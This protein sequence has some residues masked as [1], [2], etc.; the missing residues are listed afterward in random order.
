MSE[1]LPLWKVLLAE[2]K[3]L[4]ETPKP[5]PASLDEV[6]ELLHKKDRS[7]LCISGG[8]IRSASFA[9]GVIQGLAKLGASAADSVLNKIDYL[10]TV[11]GGGYVG[12]WLSGWA[13]RK[14][15]MEAVVDEL[16]KK[17]ADKL[18]PEPKPLHHLRE[19]SNYLTPKLGLLSADT[20]AF[21]GA[22][23]RNLLLMWLVLI[24]FFLAIL[25]LPRVFVSL[26]VNQI[27]I[28]PVYFKYAG[29]A[30]FYWALA[31][32][33]ITRPTA[34]PTP[35]KWIYGDY[36]FQLLCL[37]PL[38]L[39]AVTVV[40]AHSQYSFVRWPHGQWKL[41]ALAAGG[42]VLSSLI[43]T[44]R[45]IGAEG[46]G[47]WKKQLAELAAAAVSGVLLA[48]LL[49]LFMVQFESPLTMMK[50]ADT[51]DWLNGH[52]PLL[53][54]SLA[55]SYIVFG[56][57]LV[58]L[59]LLLQAT[60]FVGGTGRF[61]DDFDREWWG[62]AAAWVIIAGIGWIVVTAIVIYG[63]VG[64]YYAPRTIGLIGGVSGLFAVGA[65]KSGKTSA[66]NKE[67]TKESTGGTISNILL[68]LATPLFA[69]AL[70][71]ALSLGTTAL[72][73]VCLEQRHIIAPRPD[74]STEIEF[75]KR[76]SWT[77][78]QKQN[79][80]AVA[81]PRVAA[82]GVGEQ[83]LKTIE[84]PAIEADK[85]NGLDHLFVLE[86]TP[87]RT[88]AVLV[89]GAILIALLASSLIGVN[90]F[91]IH[92]LYRDRIVRGYLA[93]S[94]EQRKENP[95]T[96]FD[97][98]DNILINSLLRRPMHVVNMC[99][100]LAS[101]DNLAWQERKAESFTASPLH[102]G[103]LNLGY[104][105]ST[106]YG[107]PKGMKLGTAVG[108]SGAAASPNMG[109][110]SSPVMALLL[111]F[112]NVRLGWWLGNP[113]D[114][115]TY[116]LDNP[117]SSL[118]PLLAEALG[119]SDQDHAYIYLSDGGHFENL[120]LYEMVLRRCHHIVVSDAGS[121]EKFVF[122]DLGM[123]IRKIYIDFGIRVVI[124]RMGLF[125]RSLQKSERDNPKYCATGRILYSE[126]DNGGTDGDFVYI[127]PV[128]YGSE[129]QDI[130]N[131]GLMNEAFPHQSTA[132]Q[133]F[134]E[135][136]LESYRGLGEHA[137]DQVCGIKGTSQEEARKKINTIAEFIQ[138][139][140]DYTNEKP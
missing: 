82:L 23:L 31:F 89:L 38:C 19:Y 25:A 104:R 90:R 59:A 112:F 131:Y 92:A 91:S 117:L 64:I 85:L 128:F 97:P 110:H 18:K 36:A 78:E 62:R 30:L 65:G 111:T 138:K 127:K 80:T 71:A 133:F 34:R 115:V 139:A 98:N 5:E 45:K 11:S 96:G 52:V 63:P 2:Y 122:D 124:D 40:I 75:L 47:V 29:A 125:P 126:V 114:D 70:L 137:I 49:R 4:Y 68:G 81:P 21:F 76:L 66:N 8:G 10:S 86:K 69:L 44:F 39:F 35:K 53:G 87:L 67:K 118:K 73:R 6:V 13:T 60:L 9:L 51:L 42:T 27:H 108:I 95:F 15:S 57:P 103:S 107:G 14:G 88:A 119:M 101:G 54:S 129:P 28:P 32:V 135:S 20:W 134:D 56:V 140:R 48:F 7:A 109:Y 17:P 99:L 102:C 37:L 100:N 94:N 1:C 106:E 33:G 105:P 50:Q 55:A 121:D 72:L 130:Y 93:A 84:R 132:D 16:R 24:P 22:Y 41:I 74:Q 136:Q 120:G 61:N 3:H 43:Y 79:Q 58:I 83:K 46:T 113:R 77:F 12:S 26:T 123:A 116:K